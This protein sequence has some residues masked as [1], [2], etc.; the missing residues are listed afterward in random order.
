MC[1]K[2]GWESVFWR[3]VLEK[4]KQEE[5]WSWRQ[6]GHSE[7]NSCS[8]TLHWSYERDRTWLETKTLSPTRFLRQSGNGNLP[9]L[10]KCGST[11]IASKVSDSTIMFCFQD[12]SQSSKTLANLIPSLWFALCYMRISQLRILGG[13][14]FVFSE[15]YHPKYK[16]FETP[17]RQGLFLQGEGRQEER[18][19]HNPVYPP[20]KTQWHWDQN[21]LFSKRS[22]HPHQLP[23]SQGTG[24]SSLLWYS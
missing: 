10:G 8:Q 17:L 2:H 24:F 14:N 23:C 16:K 22:K 20:W 9:I 11:Y 4:S 12:K 19:K 5:K 3:R 7:R 13:C 21:I 18:R 6:S 15:E 1:P